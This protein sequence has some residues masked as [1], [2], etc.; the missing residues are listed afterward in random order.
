[1]S[2]SA[3]HILYNAFTTHSYPVESPK[4]GIF[5]PQKTEIG[6]EIVGC[7]SIMRNFRNVGLT[8]HVN[9]FPIGSGAS[10][11]RTK[12]HYEKFCFV[13]DFGDKWV[14]GW[15]YKRRLEETPWRN[16]R[17]WQRLWHQDTRL[18]TN[19]LVL[20]ARDAFG[21][22]IRGKV[23]LAFFGLP[24]SQQNEPS[25][26]YMGV[27][28]QIIHA[29]GWDVPSWALTPVARVLNPNLYVRQP[30]PMPV[31]EDL[32]GQAHIVLI[33]TPSPSP[34][35]PC[36]RKDGTAPPESKCPSTVEVMAVCH[37]YQRIAPKQSCD[38]GEAVVLPVAYKFLK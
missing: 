13:C 34:V 29:E 38:A 6:M 11:L 26:P 8:S 9:Y 20:K 22:F 28:K 17:D 23:W 15:Y 14:V 27:P 32:V 2:F 35:P 31:Y 7:D 36:A 5:P 18:N 1:M 16:D 10:Y 4:N 19:S 30:Y 21:E 24:C 25:N 33:K 37:R 12:K 3:P